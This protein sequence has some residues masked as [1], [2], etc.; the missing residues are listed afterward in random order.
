MRLPVPFGLLHGWCVTQVQQVSGAAWISLQICVAAGSRELLAVLNLM[1]CTSN[2]VEIVS[3][4]V[5]LVHYQ[6]L[7]KILTDL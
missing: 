5:G 2:E 3:L 7:P 1:W 6:P 4:F